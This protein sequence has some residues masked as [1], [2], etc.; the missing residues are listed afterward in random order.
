MPVNE[1][2]KDGLV[3]LQLFF[4]LAM[5]E[6]HRV[7]FYV[8]VIFQVFGRGSHT[9]GCLLGKGISTLFQEVFKSRVF[10][11]PSLA[12]EMAE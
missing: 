6:C 11:Q 8:G 2:L 3:S 1:I 4:P 5:D 12:V 7:S 10:S 9:F